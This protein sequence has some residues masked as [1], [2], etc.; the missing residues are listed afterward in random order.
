MPKSDYYKVESKEEFRRLNPKTQDVET[1]YRIWA[2]SKGGVYYHV[3]V[4]EDELLKSDDVLAR[5][6]KELDAI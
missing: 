6:A 1:W 5:R 3:E 2:T 4:K